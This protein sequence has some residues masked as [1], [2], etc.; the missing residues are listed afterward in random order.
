MSPS[1]ASP[2]LR[3]PGREAAH[4]GGRR[5]QREAAREAAREG[6]R[7][8]PSR[9]DAAPERGGPPGREAAREGGNPGEMRPGPQER[10]S[11]GGKFNIAHI[12]N[13]F[14]KTIFFIFVFIFSNSSID[15]FCY[16]YF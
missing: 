2:A 5:P 1:A 8:P 4:P 3:R 11:Q 6:L 9:R 13:D 12:I 16:Y 10:G 15:F 14:N 7:R